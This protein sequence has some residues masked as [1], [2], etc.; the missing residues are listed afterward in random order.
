M[1]SEKVTSSSAITDT[2]LQRGPVLAKI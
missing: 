1:K 2:A